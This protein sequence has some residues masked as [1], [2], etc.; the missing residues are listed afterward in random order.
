M[1]TCNMHLLHN[2]Q[3]HGGTHHRISSTMLLHEVSYSRYSGIR[4]KDY[5]IC[6]VSVLYLYCICT[7]SVLYLYCI[8]TVSRIDRIAIC[9]LSCEVHLHACKAVDEQYARTNNS[10]QMSLKK[11]TLAVSVRRRKHR[12]H[13]LFGL[14]KPTQVEAHG[15]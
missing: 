5:C 9:G 7:V 13:Q 3:A 8:C 11:H 6:T 2:R 15:R 12:D 1:Y 4:R 14:T 10:H